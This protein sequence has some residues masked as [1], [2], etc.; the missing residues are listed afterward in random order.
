MIIQPIPPNS[1][2][3]GYNHPLKTMF[4][5]GKLPTVK[6]G[7]YGGRLNK[8]NVSLEHLKPHSK[9]GKTELDNLVLSTKNNNQNRGSEPLRDYITIKN[10]TRYL[11]QFVNIRVGDFNGNEYIQKI[12]QTIGELI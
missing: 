1:P 12:L 9:G 7:F 6:Y 11:Q 4:L 2:A 10:V 3:F 5:K 8:K